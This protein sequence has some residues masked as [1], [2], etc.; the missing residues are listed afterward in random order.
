MVHFCSETE[1]YI[2][3]AD[4]HELSNPITQ[5]DEITLSNCLLPDDG[6]TFRNKGKCEEPQSAQ[7]RARR[8]PRERGPFLTFCDPSLVFLQLHLVFFLFVICVKFHAL[9]KAHTA[10]LIIALIG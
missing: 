4:I 2:S 8:P 9:L 10:A 6:N 1:T 5:R 3:R 7:S